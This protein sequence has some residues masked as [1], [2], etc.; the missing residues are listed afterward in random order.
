M[1][2]VF[3]DRD[4]TMT[5]SDGYF[6]KHDQLD[7]IENLAGAIKVLNK[8]F[9][10][11]IITNQPVVARGLCT[12]EDVRK[13]HDKIISDL[14]KEGAKVDGVYFCPHHPEQHADVPEHA[15]KYRIKCDCRKPGIGLIKQATQDFNIDIS[16]SFFVGDRD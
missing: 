10:V 16:G 3:L 5:K 14:Q 2:A 8:N 7:M 4:G 13:V 12:E 9:L 6:Y 15:K 11:I 1:R